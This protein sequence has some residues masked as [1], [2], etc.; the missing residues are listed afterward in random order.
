MDARTGD[1]YRNKNEALA[2][3][4][5]EEHIVELKGSKKSIQRVSRRVRMVSR[6]VNKRRVARRAMQ[7]LSRRCNRGG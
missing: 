7:K 3:G 5:P 4:V 2:A 1:L 6:L